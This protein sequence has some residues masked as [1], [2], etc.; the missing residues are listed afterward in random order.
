MREKG[1]GE[2]TLA[3]EEKAVGNPKP[4]VV[5]ASPKRAFPGDLIVQ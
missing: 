5:I 2:K 4:E 3:W 1:C